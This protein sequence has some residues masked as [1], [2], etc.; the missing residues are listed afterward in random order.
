MEQNIK[1]FNINNN[2]IKD[3]YR[4]YFVFDEEGKLKLDLEYNRGMFITSKLDSGQKGTKWGR[5][6][7][8]ADL[9]DDCEYYIYVMTSDHLDFVYNDELIDYDKF[10]HSNEVETAK[11]LLIMSSNEYCKKQK[12]MKDILLLGLEG[13]YLWF[14]IEIKYSAVDINLNNV[15]VYFPADS[16]IKYFPEIYKKNKDTFFERYL[17]IFSSMNKDYQREIEKA[18]DLLD[19]DK[20]SDE[21]LLLLLK[22]LGI[23]IK[24]NFLNNQQMRI[25]LKNAKYL[26]QYKGTLDVISKIIEL[27][28]GT[29]PV[30]V[31]QM[32]VKEYTTSENFILYQELYG[33][34]TYEFLIMLN[35]KLEENLFYQLKALID[36][37]KPART[38]ATIIFL[39][40]QC[41]VD[42]HCYIDINARIAENLESLLD[43]NRYLDNNVILAK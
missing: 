12:N 26:S 13:R 17:S 9:P 22:W 32:K 6:V 4:E 2:I 3:A 28:I 36:M 20:T 15:M 37:F 25:L 38:K 41:K 8:N 34:N 31:E 40:Q 11:K 39:S 23:N 14:A 43:S 29:K 19:V 5:L 42:S 10:F 30:I 27:F 33:S 24:G 18:C 35:Q 21:A 16:L 1:R 7:L